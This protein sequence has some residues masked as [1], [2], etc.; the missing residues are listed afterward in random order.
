M[1]RRAFDEIAHELKASLLEHTA[2]FLKE[3]GLQF[4]SPGYH[5]QASFGLEDAARELIIFGANLS[6]DYQQ[7]T[8]A[9]NITVA[10]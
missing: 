5:A 2:H 7:L 1:P 8:P 4:D 10:A 6:P 9:H 3:R